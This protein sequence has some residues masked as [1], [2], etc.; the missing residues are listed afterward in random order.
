M[1]EHELSGLRLHINL[2]I[3]KD[4]PCGCELNFNLFL[5]FIFLFLREGFHYLLTGVELVFVSKL[6]EGELIG[7][8]INNFDES[9]VE[10]DQD[11]GVK[12]CIVHLRGSEGSKFPVAHLFGFAEFF[13]DN[14]FDDF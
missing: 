11:E 4:S 3:D 8:L 1:V 5:L 2:I 12:S 6:I 7:V 14:C 9:V 10:V 13:A